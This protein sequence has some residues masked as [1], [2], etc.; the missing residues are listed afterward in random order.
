MAKKQIKKTQARASA[1][2]SPSKSRS[3]T[4]SLMEAAIE[5][6]RAA[7]SLKETYG[8]VKKVGTNSARAIKPMRQ[9]GNKAVKAVRKA[10][11]GK[12]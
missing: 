2:R 12:K 8:H 11:R 9:A 10:I 6:G 5:I 1:K 4:D 7:E 3:V